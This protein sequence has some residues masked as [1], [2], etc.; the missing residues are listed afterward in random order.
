MPRRGFGSTMYQIEQEHIYRGNGI[1]V[2]R[3]ELLVNPEHDE[4]SPRAFCQRTNIRF[5]NRIVPKKERFKL[6]IDI[7]GG[8]YLGNTLVLLARIKEYQLPGKALEF[9][10]LSFFKRFA[11]QDET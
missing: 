10:V 9:A 7:L 3:Y 2:S 11:F 8:K 6:N 4:F 5:R 1:S